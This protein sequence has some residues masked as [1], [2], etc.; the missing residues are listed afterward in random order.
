MAGEVKAPDES[1]VRRAENVLTQVQTEWNTQRPEYW[2]G[3]LEV[4][5][6]GLLRE[7]RGQ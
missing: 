2:V 1:T 6:A 3:V 7:I 5:L 4:T